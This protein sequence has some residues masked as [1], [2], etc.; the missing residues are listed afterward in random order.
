MSARQVS[1]DVVIVGAGPTGLT[2]AN[3]LGAMGV[4]TLVVECNK[5]TSD[6]PK[7]V[8]LDDEGMRTMAAVGLADTIL[9]HC[10]RATGAKY[11]DADGKLFAEVGAGSEEFGY[12]K[13]SYFHQPELEKILLRGLDRF[14]NVDVAFQT[15]AQDFEEE[16]NAVRIALLSA[17][18]RPTERRCN[19]LIG[20]DGAR[21]RGA[22]ISLPRPP[23]PSGRIDAHRHFF[24]C[25]GAVFRHFSCNSIYQLRVPRKL[26]A[27]ASQC[28]GR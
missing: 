8:V 14:D 11:Y 7:A 2:L 16:A 10:L 26:L 15:T 18:G 9:S 21:S 17:D 1:H 13:R 23:Q 5:T 3:L 25:G 20:C 6:I 22:I 27:L 28:D 4:N 24:Q 12:P 19:F